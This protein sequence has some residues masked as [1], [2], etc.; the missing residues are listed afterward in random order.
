MQVSD[1]TVVAEDSDELSAGNGWLGSY[2]PYLLYRVSGLM[3]ARL[4]GRLSAMS[5]S[6][7]QWRVLSV[8]RSYGCLSITQIVH[9]TLMEQ[10]TVSR[11][12]ANLQ[13]DGF[14]ERQPSASDSRVV[15]VS[16]TDK[17][18]ATFNEIGPSATRHQRTAL[19]GLD[20]EDLEL[21]RR[22]L[23][24]IEQNILLDR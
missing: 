23:G 4:Q 12:V 13:V 22:I 24:Q 20:Q 2:L 6:L 1:D 19:N 21:M 3:N 9:Y 8:L 16:L 10:P 17:G 14:V 11:V 18:L 15:E 7:S 5:I